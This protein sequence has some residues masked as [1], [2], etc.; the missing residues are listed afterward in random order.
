MLIG[1]EAMIRRRPG[2]TVAGFRVDRLLPR[3]GLAPTPD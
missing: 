3:P 1:K 2:D